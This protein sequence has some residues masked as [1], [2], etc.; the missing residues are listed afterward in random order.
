L[1]AGSAP[2]ERG[3]SSVEPEPA[4]VQ[5]MQRPRRKTT[6]RTAIPI[7][8]PM[9]TSCAVLRLSS[10]IFVGSAVIE[11]ARDAVGVGAGEGKGLREAEGA[12]GSMPLSAVTL[13]R[14]VSE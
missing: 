8:K 4:G 9:P 7:P 12:S 3:L 6:A 5:S 13:N 14:S 1:L 11:G 2:H 10:G